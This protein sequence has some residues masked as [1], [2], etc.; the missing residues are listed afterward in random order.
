TLKNPPAMR[1]TRFDPSWEDPLEEG[2]ATHSSDLA[3]TWGG[4]PCPSPGDLPD[5]G[6]E[7]ESSAR[8]AGS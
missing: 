6:A 8:Q 3:T 1:E 5:P 4:L 7:P 2:M